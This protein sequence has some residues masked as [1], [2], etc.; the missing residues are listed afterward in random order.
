MN[1]LHDHPHSMNKLHD[2]PHTMNKL[3][4]HP[5]TPLKPSQMNWGYLKTINPESKEI[6]TIL[7]INNT[8]HSVIKGEEHRDV[9]FDIKEASLKLN[10][11][12]TIT[13]SVACNF[14][15]VPKKLTFP[16]NQTWDD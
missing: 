6:E 11:E 5:H 3:H 16:E 15:L 7:Y 8:D 13:I 1:K 12:I 2:H 14:D 9:F 4:D 10:E